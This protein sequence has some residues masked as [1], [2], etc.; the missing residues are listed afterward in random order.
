M[1]NSTP[2]APQA[3][4]SCR[5]QKRKCDKRLPQC[6]LCIRIGRTCDYSIAEHAPPPSADDFAALQQKVADL[7]ALLTRTATASSNNHSA[8]ASHGS[9]GPSST[10]NGEENALHLLASVSPAPDQPV[11][12]PSLFFLD[13]D[14]FEYERLH[15]HPPLVKVPPGALH[16]LGDSAQL[17]A[18]IEAY[19][20]TV[21]T[22]FPIICKIRLYQHLANPATEPGA[23]LALLFLAMKLIC[24]ELPEGAPPQTQLY[25]DVKA[26]LTYIE[27]QNGYSMHVMQA[28]LLISL[29]EL[30]H[31]IYPACYLSIGHAARLGHAMGLHQRDAPQ[32]LPRFHT[33]TAQE[34]KRRVWWAVVILDRFSGIGHRKTPFA[35]YDPSLDAHLPTDDDNWD[36]G[37]L[38]VAAPLALSASPSVQAAPFARTCQAAH[39]LGKIVRHLNDKAL[40]NTY[41]FEEALQLHRTMRALTAALVQEAADDDP[42]QG[43]TLCTALAICYSALLTLYDA[44]SC[45]KENTVD[46]TEAQ[47]MMQKESVEGLREITPEAMNHARRL[48][49]FA[50]RRGGWGGLSPLA[51][52]PLYQAAA[53]YA[54]YVRESSDLQCS[55]RL[56][57]VKEILMVIDQRWRV[58]GEYM[59]IIEAT[60]YRS[61]SIRSMRALNPDLQPLCDA[62]TYTAMY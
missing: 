20:V 7:E 42:N 41:R 30:G 55:A 35:T 18:M 2:V 50:E 39:L 37:Q 22:Y 14:M 26:F 15:V 12:F 21:H 53:N 40:P 29:Y 61:A 11:T 43:P 31:A 6:T 44:N 45:T 24:S 46:T 49:A 4:S 1:E 56:Q 47:L 17:R 33:W 3:C 57:E 34:E 10:I 25:A 27:S 36:R 54:W 28:L 51:I 52:D 5:K 58:A 38:V 32:M 19:F 8:T 59:R 16:A 60:E 48:R 9:R 23:D 62:S 13:S